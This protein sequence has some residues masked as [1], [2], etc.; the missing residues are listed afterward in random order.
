MEEERQ[1]AEVAAQFLDVEI[2]MTPA[3]VTKHVPRRHV[4]D[5]KF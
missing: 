2:N 1:N 3:K 4:T 5:G